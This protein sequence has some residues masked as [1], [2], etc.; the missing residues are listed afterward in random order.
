[1]YYIVT[2]KEMYWPYSEMLKIEYVQYTR[3]LKIIL[4]NRTDGYLPGAGRHHICISIII[5]NLILWCLVIKHTNTHEKK[6]K[7]LN[8]F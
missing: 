6:I 8:A 1:M 5:D 7:R 3:A 4:T 2:R